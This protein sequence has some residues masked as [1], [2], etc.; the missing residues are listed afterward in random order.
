MAEDLSSAI[1]NQDDPK[2]VLDGAPAYLLLIDGLIAGDPGNV[3]LLAAGA[4]L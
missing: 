4:K 1:R 3:N 2:T